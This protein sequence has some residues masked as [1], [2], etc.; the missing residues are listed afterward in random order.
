[1]GTAVNLNVGTAQ[2]V[3]IPQSDIHQADVLAIHDIGI[4]SMIHREDVP[5]IHDTWIQTLGP[6]SRRGIESWGRLFKRISGLQNTLWHPNQR[7]RCPDPDREVWQV[8]LESIVAQ[9]VGTAALWRHPLPNQNHEK[10]AIFI[11][12]SSP[13]LRLRRLL[14]HRLPLLLRALLLQ[15]PPLSLLRHASLLGLQTPT[16]PRKLQQVD[17]NLALRKMQQIWPT[18][19]T[20]NHTT[21]LNPWH[22]GLP[23]MVEIVQ[24]VTGHAHCR[25]F[26][27]V[28]TPHKK[29][30]IISTRFQHVLYSLTFAS[31]LH[32][33][34]VS[35]I[36]YIFV[37]L[38]VQ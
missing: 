3:I 5:E 12:P 34:L 37:F 33:S 35:L 24:G 15:P 18:P 31:Q 36:L 32:T 16:Y 8:G 23:D 27:F 13:P 4:Q 38:P 26:P 20:R 21:N 2:G 11:G 10:V 29:S 17:L 28:F 6:L 7:L 14:G 25:Q 30:H 19:P 9:G 22:T 1:M